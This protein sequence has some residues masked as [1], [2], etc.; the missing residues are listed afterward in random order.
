[1]MDHF[2]KEIKRLS[3]QMEKVPPNSPAYKAFSDTRTE[4]IKRQEAEQDKEE[5]I[6]STSVE[7]MKEREDD[8][9]IAL[10]RESLKA[11]ERK[12]KEKK[13]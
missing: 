7:Q 3:R 9:K 2:N 4:Y 8:E 13:K 6:K 12:E 5:G 11:R 10:A 1:M